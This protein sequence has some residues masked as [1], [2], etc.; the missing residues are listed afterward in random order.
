MLSPT[1]FFMCEELKK[2][3]YTITTIDSQWIVLVSKGKQHFYI[4]VANGPPSRSPT[5]VLCRN[6]Y[7]LKQ[8]ISYFQFPTA[9][10]V[11][12]TPATIGE[13]KKLRFPV[14]VKPLSGFGGADVVVGVS[15]LEAIEAY[16]RKRPQY[17][18]AM[19]EETLKGQ[20]TRILIV[21][22]KFFAAVQRQPAFIITD[23]K[24][25][26]ETCILKENER[27][28]E[29]K[30]QD[31]SKNT[32]TTDLELILYDDQVTATIA[33]AGHT[34]DSILPA[35]MKLFVRKNANVSTGGIS[36]DVTDQVCAGMRKQCEEIAE[37]LCR[38]LI[39]ID[40]MSEDLSRPLDIKNGSGVIEVNS[41]PGLDLH[42][43]TDEGQ[44][45]NPIPLII[46]EIE[47]DLALAMSKKAA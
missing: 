3:G 14:V 5:Y 28:S 20:D 11:K 9:A 43:L 36:I 31:R 38:T 26:I 40:V 30:R 46:D 12:V 1:T 25:S 33:E 44:R 21:R 17:K 4:D 2:R 6:K 23:G 15:D 45:R 10:Y 37:A 22:G 34:K 35:G 29:L 47:E 39:G 8:V 16:F 42:V 18:E 13:A 24:S 27:R 41:S 7:V 32:F 19:V